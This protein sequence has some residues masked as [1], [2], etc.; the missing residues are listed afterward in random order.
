MPSSPADAPR[1]RGPTYQEL[2]RLVLSRAMA[3]P[4]P[5]REPRPG[6]ARLA[7]DEILALVAELGEAPAVTYAPPAIYPMSAPVFDDRAP[8]DR[9]EPPGGPLGVYVHVPYCN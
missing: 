9:G 2:A 7:A 4:A 3:P 1:S 6:G 8:A 5:G